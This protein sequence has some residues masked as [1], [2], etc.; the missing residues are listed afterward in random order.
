M[1]GLNRKG[2]EAALIQVAGAPQLAESM[3]PANV[4]VHEPSHERRDL[5]SLLSPNDQVK[6]IGHDDVRQDR[7][8]DLLERVTHGCQEHLVVDVLREDRLASISTI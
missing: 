2:L 6:M 4:R 1:V 3:V 7:N 8:G 5:R